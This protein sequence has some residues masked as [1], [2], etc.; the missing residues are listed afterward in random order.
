MNATATLASAIQ[1]DLLR[2]E[3]A[4]TPDGVPC[5]A[6]GR[7][8]MPRP[9]TADDNTHTFCSTRCRDAYD[10]GWPA[11]DPEEYNRLKRLP[12]TA[13]S[14]FR[15]VAGPPGVTEFNPLKGSQQLSRGINRGRSRTGWLIDC[16]GCGKEFDSAGL[17]CCSVEC[18]RRYLKRGE[19]DELMAEVGMERPTKRKCEAPGCGKDIPNWTNGRRTSVTKR[20][21]SPKCRQRAQKP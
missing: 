3:P 4:K 12:F 20:F 13:D 8:F 17:R 9:N 1:R 14:K 16:F 6:C 2:T 18:E 21:C 11:Y 10:K 15:I 7:P 19:N 5:H